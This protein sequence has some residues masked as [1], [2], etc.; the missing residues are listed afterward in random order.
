MEQQRAYEGEDMDH[1]EVP[2][3]DNQTRPSNIN[4]EQLG[5]IISKAN[6]LC[7]LVRE[8]DPAIE[9]QLKVINGKEEHMK[10][11]KEEQKEQAAKKR[12]QTSIGDFLAKKAKQN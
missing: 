2:S 12:K 6:E 5:L 3:N 1:T 11:Y 8:L 9:R 10:D 7:D 4:L